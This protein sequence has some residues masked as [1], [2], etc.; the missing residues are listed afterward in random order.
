MPFLDWLLF[1]DKKKNVMTLNLG[2]ISNI[3]FIP[4]KSKKRDV[5]GF[6]TGP[7]MSLIGECVN[8]FW[9][10]EYDKNGEYSSKG[11]INK[12]MLD[13]LLNNTPFIIESPPKSTGR[14]EFG[15][16]FLNKVIKKYNS[17]KK[18]DILRTLVKFTSVSIKSNIEQFILNKHLVDNLIV[19]GGGAC[20]PIL[21]DDIK[22]DLD[23]PILNIIDYG[24][25]SKI[26][27]SLLMSVLG[28]AKIKNIKSSM[29]NV[30][31]ASKDIALGEIYGPE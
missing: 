11:S 1:K 16:K 18:N 7:G 30:T 8:R 12:P 3:S 5:V 17:V 24:I 22:K 2:G 21:M 4:K 10:K 9:L 13:Y 15:I 27:E 14:E 6:D 26:K 31:G 20:H 25:E 19:S 23:I 28:Y 29:P